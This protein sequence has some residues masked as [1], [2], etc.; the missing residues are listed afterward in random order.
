MGIA[1]GAHVA[2]IAELR[3]LIA[4]YPSREGRSE[5][6]MLALYKAG[7]QADALSAYDAVR[8]ALRDEWRAPGTG[9]PGDASTHAAADGCL[10]DPAGQHVVRPP[11]DLARGFRVAGPIVACP[12]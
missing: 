7:R 6:L 2:A 3:A 8:H 10:V 11:A 12:G 5:L 1:A 4:D 9:P